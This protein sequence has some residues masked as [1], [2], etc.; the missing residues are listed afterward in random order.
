MLDVS[1]L[2][3]VPFYSN[4]QNDCY[5]SFPDFEF[6]SFSLQEESI[7]GTLEPGSPNFRNALLENMGR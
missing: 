7:Q 4:I 1:F 3:S 2:K 6:V 5:I